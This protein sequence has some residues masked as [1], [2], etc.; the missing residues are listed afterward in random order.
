MHSRLAD[1]WDFWLSSGRGVRWNLW[2][3]HAFV[4]LA[5]RGTEGGLLALRK[6]LPSPSSVVRGSESGSTVGQLHHVSW[7]LLQLGD[8]MGDLHGAL[9]TGACLLAL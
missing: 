4:E 5:A 8:R 1:S 2:Q 9:R 3:K 6:S 7:S